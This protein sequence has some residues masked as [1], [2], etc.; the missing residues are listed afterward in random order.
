MKSILKQL[1]VPVLLLS[2]ASGAYAQ[3]EQPGNGAENFMIAMGP[4][5]PETTREKRIHDQ[6]AE[7]FKSDPKL[8]ASGIEVKEVHNQTVV[9]RGQAATEEERRHAQ[10]IAIHVAG[11]RRVEAD[12]VTVTGG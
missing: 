6:V 1:T 12:Q 7:Q 11:V 8:Q 5:A 4:E 3:R 10:Y 9:L 2:L